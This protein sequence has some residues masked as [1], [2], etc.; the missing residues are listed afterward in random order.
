M[1]LTLLVFPKSVRR[2][3]PPPPAPL[4]KKHGH[5][6]EFINILIAGFTRGESAATCRVSFHINGGG[7]N[8]AGFS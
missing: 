8:L 2:Q 6:N 7:G 4:M 3:I 1:L 5:E